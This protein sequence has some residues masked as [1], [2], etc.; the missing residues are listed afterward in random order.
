MVITLTDCGAKK[1][2]ADNVKM[3]FPVVPEQIKY[4]TSALFQEYAVINKGT[5]KIPSGTDVTTIGWECFF[6]GTKIQPLPFV[7]NAK[8]TKGSSSKKKTP[9]EMHK[10]LETW[11]DNG[12]KLKLNITGSPFS[13][14]VYID[15]YEAILQD[16]HGSIYYNIEFSKAID[17]TV[18]TVSKKTVTKKKTTT[19]RTS[20]TTT[21]KKHKVKKGDCLWNIAKKYYKDGSKWKK[22]YNANKSTIEKA[23]KKHGKKS[24][25]NGHW[26]Y[27][28]TVLKIP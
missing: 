4:S 21:Q 12:A 1:G 25:S 9:T 13:F 18:D 27:P 26:I 2:T 8:I 10:Q 19:K 6:P 22:I 17:I 5:V 7:N 23:A 28:G 24:S 11:R 3:Y 14:Y 15:K 16:A 20:K